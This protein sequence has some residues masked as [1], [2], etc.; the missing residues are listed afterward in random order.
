[1][2]QVEEGYIAVRAGEILGLLVAYKEGLSPAAIRLYLAGVLAAD[3]QR[4]NKKPIALDKLINL[5][6]LTLRTAQEAMRELKATQL[7]ALKGGKL[8]FHPGVIP[9]AEPYV[10]DLETRPKRPVPIPKPIL[11]MLARQANAS[12]L[13][14][15]LVHLLRC[16]FIDK[17]DINNK[18]FVKDELIT[19]LT[20]LCSRTIRRARTWMKKIGLLVENPVSAEIKTRFGRLFMVKLNYPTD[21]NSSNGLLR[22]LSS[23]GDLSAGS[24]PCSIYTNN[25]NQ[26]PN[27]TREPEPES[28]SGV[29]SKQD[30]LSPKS[31][32]TLPHAPTLNDIQPVDLR[33]VSRL[34]ALYR[35]AVARQWLPDC[36]ASIQ[37]FV[38]AATRAVQVAGNAVKIFVGIVKRG[39]WNYITQG[40]EEDSLRILNRYL[41]ENPGAFGGKVHVPDKIPSA[42]AGKL[43]RADETPPAQPVKPQA[44]RPERMII[45][46]GQPVI[47]PRRPTQA[48]TTQAVRPET[49]PPPARPEPATPPRLPPKT[50]RPERMIIR[51]GRPVNPPTQPARPARPTRL[52]DFVSEVIHQIGTKGPKMAYSS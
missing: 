28:S 39:L 11:R 1:M 24:L 15:A 33:E 18:G 20:G 27:T 36:Q 10:S 41:A 14:G 32:E 44:I 52:G 29:F 34:E 38:A 46:N 26:Y 48:V 40:Q 49:P 17:G 21:S 45:R 4:L 31:E 2:N 35:Q 13:I 30:N 3:R 23:N 16:L 12:N 43:H 5:T 9:V 22:E 25:K 7:M 50:I 47:P 51:R 19:R 6:G 42:F 8:T 37:N